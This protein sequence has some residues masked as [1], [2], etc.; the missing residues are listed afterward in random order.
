MRAAGGARG[1]LP[2]AALTSLARPESARRATRE[3][4]PP[5][6]PEHSPESAPYRRPTS[7]PPRPRH[8]PPR[9]PLTLPAR[10]G[11]SSGP[12]YGVSTDSAPALALPRVTTAGHR[13]LRPDARTRQ[14]SLAT[15]NNKKAYPTVL[16]NLSRSGIG[17][18]V[19]V[20]V[21]PHLLCGYIR[22]RHVLGRRPLSKARLCPCSFYTP[23]L[24]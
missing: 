4:H 3:P 12:E 15:S 24:N 11:R 8:N 16:S 6:R 13:G 9:A 14:H 19:L 23:S 10:C 20:Q 18:R 1:S 2:S 7:P 21:L 17:W 22:N 5:A